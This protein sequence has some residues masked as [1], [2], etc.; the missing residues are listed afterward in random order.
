MHWNK[1]I[2]HFAKASELRVDSIP[3]THDARDESGRHGIE[4]VARRWAV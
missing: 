2:L 4:S 1:K 3:V